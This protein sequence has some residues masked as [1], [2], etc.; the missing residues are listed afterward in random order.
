MP[1][2][3]EVREALG[4]LME[5]VAG[6]PIDTRAYGQP[7]WVR[8]DGLHVT[9]RFLGATPD[10]LQS[11]LARAI[12]RTAAGRSPFQIGLSGGGAFPNPARPRVLWIGIVTGAGELQELA[13][14]LAVELEALG[15]PPEDRPFAP[16]LTLARTDGVPGAAER[17]A[18]LEELAGDVRLEWLADRLVLYRSVLGRGPA[19]YEEVAAAALG[20]A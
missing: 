15:W 16:H 2:S 4:R 13:G 11:D 5:D 6:G 7:R 9:L 19:R 14:R 10:E 3:E 12:E 18:R 17:A 20:Q 8:V 1:V